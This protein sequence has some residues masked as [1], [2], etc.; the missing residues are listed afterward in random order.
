MSRLLPCAR[1]VG[2]TA[3]F[4]V[5]GLIARHIVVKPEWRLY[6]GVLLGSANP[7]AMRTSV[8]LDYAW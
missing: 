3:D 2:I 8:A 7:S 4:G 5:H 6:T 1:G